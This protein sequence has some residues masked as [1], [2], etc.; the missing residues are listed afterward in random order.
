LIWLLDHGAL[1]YAE[2]YC[3]ANLTRNA[4][5]VPGYFTSKITNN[6]STIINPSLAIPACQG[7]SKS[8]QKRGDCP[9]LFHEAFEIFGDKSEY[10]VAAP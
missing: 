4:G 9:R 1:S 5:T 8:G 2:P 3:A 6:H 7:L 10:V